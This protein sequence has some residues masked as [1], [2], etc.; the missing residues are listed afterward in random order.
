MTL[1]PGDVIVT[2]TPGGVGVKRNPPLWLQPGDD[3]E[4][5]ISSVG[6]LRNPV[7]Q[8]ALD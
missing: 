6:L 4:V 2:G 1:N 5:E 3:V 7:A 8:E